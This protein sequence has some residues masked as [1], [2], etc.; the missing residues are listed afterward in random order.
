MMHQRAG[1]GRGPYLVDLQALRVGED[2]LALAAGQQLL[3][4]VRAAVEVEALVGDEHLVADLAV[5][6]LLALVGRQVLRELVAL[7][8]PVPAEPALEGLGAG[9]RPV[10]GLPV[11]LQG[12]GLVAVGAAVRL[13]AVVD[14]L[15][16]D[17]AQQ[18]RVRLAAAPA[19][20]GLL[21]PVDPQVGLQVGRLVEA[22]LALGAVRHLPAG[23]GRVLPGPAQLRVIVCGGG[24]RGQRSRCRLNAHTSCVYM[25]PI[26]SGPTNDPLPG[27]WSGLLFC[28][29][30]VQVYFFQRDQSEVRGER[31]TI[32]AS[33]SVWVAVLRSVSTVHV[34]AASVGPVRRRPIPYPETGSPA[35]PATPCSRSA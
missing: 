19:L 23:V 7:A 21:A 3:V 34:N 28:T 6:A 2:L 13:G 35:P 17:E 14:L 5:V 20:V 32:A 16:D 33:G 9:V 10:V 18:G 22:L 25:C 15:V 26:R 1:P 4:P 24:V 27:S 12:E 29:C 30:S 31:V 8:E 11:A